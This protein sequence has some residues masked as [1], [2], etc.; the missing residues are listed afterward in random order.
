MPCCSSSLSRFRVQ[1]ILH[2]LVDGSP[3]NLSLLARRAS[4]RQAASSAEPTCAWL[5]KWGSSG[6]SNTLP[7]RRASSPE[8]VGA[9]RAQMML[10]LWT[11]KR[12][13]RLNT[14]GL[15]TFNRCFGPSCDRLSLS[16]VC[17]HFYL[18]FRPSLSVV[19]VLPIALFLAC[20]PPSRPLVLLFPPS[21]SP[22]T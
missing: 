19:T 16:L 2:W 9:S 6:L 17:L 7:S 13:S 22:R 18:P 14:V 12:Y 3:L 20:L 11:P 5:R 8:P 1:R 21:L 15:I 10:S 4:F